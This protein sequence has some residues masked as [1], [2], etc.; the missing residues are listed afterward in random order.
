MLF[1]LNLFNKGKKIEA[2]LFSPLEGV[3]TFEGRPAS[4]AKIKRKVAWKDKE[5]EI[6]Y[7]TTDEKGHFS[8]PIKTAEYRDSPYAQISIR[9]KLTVEFKGK[10]YMIWRAGKSTTHL[11]GELGGRPVNLVCELTKEKLD[12]HPGFSL[13]KTLCVWNELDQSEVDKS[14]LDT[15]VS[16]I[17]D[18]LEKRNK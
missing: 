11:Y 16:D 6:D 4:G 1:L 14:K 12:F 10:E 2:V 3:I 18:E 9:Q 8:I 17:L 7:F 5:G 15:D 13:L